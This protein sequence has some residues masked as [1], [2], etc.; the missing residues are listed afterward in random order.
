[1]KKVLVFLLTLFLCFSFVACDDDDNNSGIAGGNE[2]LVQYIEENGEDFLEGLEYGF[3][4]S[5]NLTCTSSIKVIGT[6][7]VVDINIQEVDD[8]SEEIKGQMQATYD[9]M[10]GTFNG[11]LEDL[12][13]EIP[14]L[15]YMTFN[16]CDKDGDLLAQIS[17]GK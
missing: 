11:M 9:A 16:I 13:K 4:T 10:S 15:T 3:A 1:M 12:Q 17:A 7:F 5:S 14:A 2:S 6:G 8:V